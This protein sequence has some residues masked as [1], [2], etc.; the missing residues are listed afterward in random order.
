MRTLERLGI[1]FMV[2][3]SIASSMYGVYRATN[4]VDVVVELHEPQ[5]EAFC[6]ALSGKFYIDSDTIRDALA[7]GRPFNI[8]HLSTSYKIDLF[9]LLP[10]PYSQTEFGRR[11]MAESDMGCEEVVKFPVCTAEDTILAKLVWYKKGGEVSE[12][13]WS[14]IRGIVEVQ[15]GRLD[16]EYMRK[17]ARH[18]SVAELLERAL[19]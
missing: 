15:A 14:D 4:D 12:R 5:V 17:W 10:D 9:P 19:S 6:A 16:S 11:V 8:I 2:G 1:P 18:L 3:G 13:Q 7:H